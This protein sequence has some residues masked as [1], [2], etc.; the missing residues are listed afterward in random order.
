MSV[1]Q[2]AVD[3]ALD[4]Q[5]QINSHI[6]DVIG[7]VKSENEDIGGLLDILLNWSPGML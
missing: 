7:Q 1:G 4:N 5:K 2:E 6:E 3:E